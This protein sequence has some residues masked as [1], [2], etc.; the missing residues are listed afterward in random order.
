MFLLIDFREKEEE[1]HWSAVPPAHAFS[2]WYLYVLR[3][4]MKLETLAYQYD[5][6]TNWTTQPGP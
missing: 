3:P 6:P 2:D 5:T 1:K 4:G